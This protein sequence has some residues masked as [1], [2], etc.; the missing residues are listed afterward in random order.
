MGKPKG[1]GGIGGAPD[2]KGRK[3]NPEETANFFSLITFGYLTPLI[4]LGSKRPLNQEDLYELCSWDQ[5]EGLSER[6]DKCYDEVR[7]APPALAPVA[8]KI[9]SPSC[10][11]PC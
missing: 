3:A 2:A 6:L 11:P 9:V 10:E 1:A 8:L 7:P 5:A 4:Q